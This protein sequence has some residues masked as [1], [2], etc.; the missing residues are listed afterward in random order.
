MFSGGAR[1]PRSRGGASVALGPKRA[2]PKTLPP[3][4]FRGE[5]G[6]ILRSFWHHFKIILGSFSDHV[7]IIFASFWH[8][9]CVFMTCST[10]E[11]TKLL[12][13][14]SWTP[15][16]YSQASKPSNFMSCW[17]KTF[18]NEQL[19]NR[20]GFAAYVFDLLRHNQKANQQAFNMKP[21]KIK[22]SK[23]S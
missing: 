9:C 13:T 10:F 7:G 18:E 16:W 5:A 15:F 11:Y 1:G 23:W 3:T 2:R 20:R 14:S 12:G 17:W 22:P 4:N 6:I 21:S 19:T 8:H